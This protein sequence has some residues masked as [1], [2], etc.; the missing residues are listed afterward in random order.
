MKILVAY[1]S[2][3]NSTAEIASAI[4]ELLQQSADFQVDVRSVETIKDISSYEAVILGSAVYMAQWQ[5]TAAEFLKQHEQ[6]L[7]Q[8]PVWLFS[9]GPIGQEDPVTLLKG[10]EF[11]EALQALSM[12]IK[13]RDIVLFHGN[14]DPIEL[15]LL[16]RSAV[17]LIHAKIGDSRDWNVIR[18]WANN[19]SQT[20]HTEVLKES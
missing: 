12:R 14:L 19:I 5:S 20:L 9:S 3:H 7:T 1:A 11:P 16:E 8:R 2:K 6:E 17:K 10:W 13:P 15:N 18:A 4:G